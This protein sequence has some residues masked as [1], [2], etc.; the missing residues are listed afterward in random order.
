M[1]PTVLTI[2]IVLTLA[3]CASTNNPASEA[4][5]FHRYPACV[6][7]HVGGRLLHDP[8]WVVAEHDGE[9]SHRFEFLSTYWGRIIEVSRVNRFCSAL[10]TRLDPSADRSYRDRNSTTFP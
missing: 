6:E 5:H 10:R 2:A 8:G 1:K 9:G 7:R 3:S 4:E